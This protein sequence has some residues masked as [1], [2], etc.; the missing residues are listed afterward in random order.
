MMVSNAFVTWILKD[1]VG[2]DIIKE[3]I[4]PY[5]RWN[6]WNEHESYMKWRSSINQVLTDIKINIRPYWQKFKYSH[7]HSSNITDWGKPII[8]LEGFDHDFI[9]GSKKC[10]C[11]IVEEELNWNEHQCLLTSDTVSDD[12]WWNHPCLLVTYLEKLDP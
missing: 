5:H 11:Q 7:I 4:L 8:T 1:K 12:V 6:N 9:I 10:Y 2:S 3:H